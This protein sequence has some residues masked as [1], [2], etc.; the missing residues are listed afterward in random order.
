MLS[1]AIVVFREV[2]EIVLIVGIVLAAT[3]GMPGRSKAI[4]IGFAGGIAGSIL[5]AFFTGKIS[6]LAE[7]MGQEYFNAAIL[8]I[9]AGFIGWTLLWMKKHAREMKSNFQKLGQEVADGSVPFLSLSLV[10]ALAILREGSEIALFTYGMLATGQSPLSIT[11]GSIIG[12]LGGTIVGVLLYL[13]LI[14]LSLRLFFKVTGALLVVLVAG[15][16]SQGIGFLTAAGAFENLSFTVWD[17]SWLLNEQSIIGESL[18]TLAGY[19]ARPTAIQLIVYIS[20]LG[21]LIMLIQKIGKNMRTPVTAALAAILAFAV[22]ATAH[23]SKTVSSPYVEKG[24]VELES[25]TGYD[26]DDDNDVDGAWKE[27]N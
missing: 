10:I 25:K 3:K 17:S 21:I 1:S 18:K 8:F 6:E 23:A 7:G 11:A 22:P 14:Q 27:K 24:E 15:M 19:T 4:S 20:T 16:M 26:I 2:F 13:G 9:A 5:V 12:L